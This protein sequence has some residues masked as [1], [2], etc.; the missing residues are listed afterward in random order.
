MLNYLIQLPLFSYKFNNISIQLELLRLSAQKGSYRSLDG[1][2][3][4]TN[5]KSNMNTYSSS[6]HE[7]HIKSNFY[8]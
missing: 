2:D 8:N 1:L 5:L 7:L 4:L 3:L 6:A